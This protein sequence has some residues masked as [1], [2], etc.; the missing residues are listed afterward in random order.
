MIS[1]PAFVVAIVMA[2]LVSV[3]VDARPAITQPNAKNAV[4]T[5]VDYD[6]IKFAESSTKDNGLSW[7]HLTGNYKSTGRPYSAYF[8]TFHPSYFSFY[9]SSLGG[10]VSLVKTSQSSHESW[11][12]CAFATNG[13]FFDTNPAH[14][15]ADNG[16]LCVGN[17]ISSDQSGKQVYN[18]YTDAGTGRANFGISLVTQE[19]IIGFIDGATPSTIQFSQLMS[20]WGWVVRDGA[21]NV[22]HSQDLPIGSGFVSEKAPRTAVGAM[23]DGRMFLLEIDGEEDILAGPDLHEQAELLVSLGVSSAV[24][25][26]GGGSSVAVANGAVVDVPT[27]KDTP[28]VCERAVASF[29]CVQKA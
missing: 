14:L 29:T 10:C 19:M 11:S 5:T 8:A 6:V 25:I 15:V 27:C 21:S 4:T 12:D 13:G 20:G 1:L 24:N 28:E 16:T 22:D 7:E 23:P 18:Q 9:P 26:D 3:L 17:L 2:V